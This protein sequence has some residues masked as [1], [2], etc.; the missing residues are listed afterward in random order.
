MLDLHPSFFRGRDG[1]KGYVLAYSHKCQTSRPSSVCLVLAAGGGWSP[2]M[3]R[4]SVTVFVS[5]YAF[6]AATTPGSSSS[7]CLLLSASSGCPLDI[8]QPWLSHAFV[9]AAFHLLCPPFAS[10]QPPNLSPDRIPEKGRFCLGLLCIVALCEQSFC[11]GPRRVC[12]C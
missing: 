7:F 2:A 8:S 4:M 6:P 11:S 5:A 10:L 12:H 1:S 9:W 3:W